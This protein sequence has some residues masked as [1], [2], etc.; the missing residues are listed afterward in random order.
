M[1]VR[2]FCGICVF[3]TGNPMAQLGYFHFHY[4]QS[5]TLVPDRYIK[6]KHIQ[7]SYPLCIHFQSIVSDYHRS[8]CIFVRCYADIVSHILHMNMYALLSLMTKIAWGLQTFIDDWIMTAIKWICISMHTKGTL[9][10]A[11]KWNL[12]SG[13]SVN[14]LTGLLTDWLKFKF[15][16][17]FQYSLL[18]AFVYCHDVC[19][20]WSSKTW[21]WTER[22]RCEQTRTRELFHN[23]AKQ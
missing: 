14:L 11:T 7:Y 3:L 15:L 12:I 4:F 17:I 1:S 5:V 10:D 2:N 6:H 23:T 16:W 8:I 20:L 22:L 13:W 21:E 18:L 9:K 19:L